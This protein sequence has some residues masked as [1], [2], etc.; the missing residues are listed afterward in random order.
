M[1]DVT[2]NKILNGNITLYQPKKGFRI[3]IDSILL[4]SSVNNYKNCLDLGSGVGVIMLSLAKRFPKSRILG[5]DKNRELIKISKEN[6]ILNNLEGLNI[7]FFCTDIKKGKFLPELNNSFD[8]VVMNPPYF[9]QN[10][11]VSSIDKYKSQAKYEK[12]IFSWFNSAYSKLK[13]KGHINFIFRSEFLNIA[14]ECLSNKWG[15]IR[16][17][18]LWPKTGKVSKLTI[19]Q[20]RKNSKSGVQLMS[21]LVLHNNDGTYTEACKKILNNKSYIDI[22]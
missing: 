1:I 5:V 20:A 3:G 9:Y 2:K 17:F 19:I 4:S 16:I 21:G 12:N 7:K 14:L 22:D 15:D 6:V 11:V 18:P 13:P 8:R 10:K